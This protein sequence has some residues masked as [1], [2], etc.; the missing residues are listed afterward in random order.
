[1]KRSFLVLILLVAS[2]TFAVAS[3]PHSTLTFVKSSHHHD[4]RVQ[5]HRAHKTGKHHTPRHPH[6]H[7]V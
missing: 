7:A 3:T 1:M 6:H 4:K 5:R 2:G